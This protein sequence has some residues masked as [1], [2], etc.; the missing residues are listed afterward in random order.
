MAKMS[1]L[2]TETFEAGGDLSADQYK[3]VLQAADSQVDLVGVLGTVQATGVLLNNPSAQGQ[4]AT[5]AV[6]GVPKVKAAVTLA[7]GDKISSDAAG[8]ALVSIAT[9]HVLGICEND[10]AAGEL[11]EVRLDNQGI[12]A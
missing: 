6:G 2:I 5:V 12:L 10:A 8:L 3:F 4:A 1:N 7:P 11:A 9:Y